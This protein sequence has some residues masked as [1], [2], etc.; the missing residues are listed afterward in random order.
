[1]PGMGA[2]N[3]GVPFLSQESIP[4]ESSWQ[5]GG[6]GGSPPLNSGFLG[7]ERSLLAQVGLFIHETLKPSLS[8]NF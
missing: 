5:S 4:G 1:M 6:G 2:L 7:C 3:R 8:W